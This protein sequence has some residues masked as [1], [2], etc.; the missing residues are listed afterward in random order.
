MLTNIY[1]ENVMKNIKGFKGV[2]SSNN[3]P[4][5]K[6]NMSIIVNFD[7]ENEPGSHFVAIFKKRK[8]CL[9]FDSLNCNFIPVEIARYLYKY[10]KIK[11]YSESL[12]SLTSTYCGFY[13]MLFIL[14]QILGEKK[15]KKVL[16]YFKN[17]KNNNDDICIDLICKIILK[18]KKKLLHKIKK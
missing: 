18:Y 1:L 5:L 3:T 10:D 6:N 11:N 7:K 4:D 9:Y 16:K 2:F 13:C 14:C 12:Q 17:D 8:Y 15:W